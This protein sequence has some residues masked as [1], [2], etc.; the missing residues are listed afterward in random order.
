MA[1]KL[2][3]QI[4]KGDGLGNNFTGGILKVFEAGQPGALETAQPQI[5]DISDIKNL[6]LDMNPVM[7]NGAKL[8]MGRDMFKTVGTMQDNDGR[9][10]LTH[11]VI[12]DKP[13]YMILGIPV[14][15][16]EEVEAN[17]IVLGNIKQGMKMKMNDGIEISV[18]ME[19]FKTSGQLGIMAEFYGDASVVDKQA[20]RV[21]RI[22]A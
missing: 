18:L 19:A 9:F 14:E 5:I 6:I 7:L 12:G 16:T 8:Y 4:F 15:I 21:L 11:D 22:K 13:V 20:F 17:T 2:E 10:F 1:L 3:E